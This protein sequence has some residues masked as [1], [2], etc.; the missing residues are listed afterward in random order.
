MA[1]VIFEAAVAGK[2]FHTSF[3]FKY[4]DVNLFY[5]FAKRTESKEILRWISSARI[6]A[7]SNIPKQWLWIDPK[8]ILQRVTKICEKSYEHEFHHVLGTVDSSAARICFFL[9]WFVESGSSLQTTPRLIYFNV[10]ETTIKNFKMK[11]TWMVQVMQKNVLSYKQMKI[12]IISTAENTVRSIFKVCLVFNICFRLIKVQTL[13][14]TQ[15][16]SKRQR[17]IG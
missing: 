5:L 14:L 4:P 10:S 8:G 7:K 12:W 16:A 6:T 15:Y 13:V 9:K 1:A 11:V 17:R 2:S 3:V